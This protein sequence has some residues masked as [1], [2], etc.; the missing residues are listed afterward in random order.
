MSGHAGEVEEA[1][2]QSGDFEAKF[3]VTV[4]KADGTKCVRCWNY[5]KA[6]GADA[7]HPQLCEKC[8]DALK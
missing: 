3:S 5:S 8:L 2:Y 6:V 4:A 1:V 7:K